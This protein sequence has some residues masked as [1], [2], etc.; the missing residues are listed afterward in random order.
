M[1]KIKRKKIII[2]SVYLMI[3]FLF[4]YFIYSIFRKKETCFDNI[5]N[6]NEEAVDCGGVC[7]KKCEKIEAQDLIIKKTGIVPAG[8]SGKYD[9]YAEI[10][11]PNFLFGSKNFEYEISL[12]NSSG[13]TVISK[14]GNNFILPGEEKYLA[15]INLESQETLVSGEIKIVS[16]EW[17]QFNQYYESPKL[18]ITNKI[19]N[20]LSDGTNFSEAKGLL[21]NESEFDFYTIKIQIILLGE[22]GKVLALNS[23]RMNTVKSGEERDF[24]VSWP[25]QF[26]GEVLGVEMRSEVNIFSQDVFLKRF[27]KNENFQKY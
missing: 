3:F 21:K 2:A 14:K 4:F 13:E 24:R 12:K 9:F 26:P 7:Q 1:E 19:Y 6:Q 16:S 18:K 17:V 8:L 22:N 20:K 15:E 27:Y 25:S 11:N 10:Y 23:T 5:Q